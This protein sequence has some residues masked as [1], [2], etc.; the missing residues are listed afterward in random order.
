M[1]SS[2]VG[3]V[4]VPLYTRRLQTSDYGVLENLN[5]IALFVTMIFG[6]SLPTALTRFWISGG[7]SAERRGIMSSATI[8]TVL[9][10]LIATVCGVAAV[11]PLG[12]LLVRKSTTEN[13]V[14]L[15][16]AFTWSSLGM[17]FS[18]FLAAFRAEF[19]RRSYLVASVGVVC[20]S[21]L[22]NLLFVLRLNAG[23]RGILMA[24]CLSYIV[25]TVYAWCQLR[26]AISLHDGSWAVARRLLAFGAPFAVTAFLSYV[27]RAGDRLFIAVLL[28]A[29]LQKMGLFAIAEK[30]MMPLTLF[31]FAFGNAWAPFAMAAEKQQDARRVYLATFR[32]YVSLTALAMI[33]CSLVAPW[34]I[35]LLTTPPYYGSYVYTAGIGIYLSLD[36][37]YY[38][39]SVGLLIAGR[40]GL[41]IPSIAA[42]ALLNVALNYVL[43]PRYEIF[44]AIWARNVAL[45]VYNLLVFRAGESYFRVGF[46]L[47]RCLVLYGTAFL[48]AETGLMAP[49]AVLILVPGYAI[50]LHLFGFLTWQDLA[51]FR[52]DVTALLARARSVSG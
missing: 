11:R 18:L 52:E 40:S 44:G 13:A 32:L 19:R 38:I 50:L 31:G 2:S 49:S 16:L 34:L 45:L 42:A 37:L 9:L 26:P 6:L 21:L 30:F 51:R 33:G 36:Y 35:R 10:A 43:I 46:P 23:V 4:L 20:L 5:T 47:G 15:V 17:L 25:F 29:S 48:V 41:L 7:A 39:G 8:A 12:N 14:L 22:L 28:P 27:V 1:L 3:V 24:S